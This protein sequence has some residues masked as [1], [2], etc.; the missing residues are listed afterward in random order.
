MQLY[1]P[2]Q[3]L[4]TLNHAEIGIHRHHD[5]LITCPSTTNFI[6][7]YGIIAIRA[8]NT[9]DTVNGL[10]VKD[11]PP[12]CPDC[13]SSY[14]NCDFAQRH[15]A[16]HQFNV[17]LLQ[18][19]HTNAFVDLVKGNYTSL[20]LLPSLISELT[21]EEKKKI[22]FCAF[23]DLWRCMWI[24]ICRKNAHHSP[25]YKRAY[26]IYRRNA[27]SILQHIDQSSHHNVFTEFGFP[28]G[29]RNRNESGL[30][31][32]IREFV[33]ESGYSS[34]DLEI[35]DANFNIKEEFVGSDNKYYRHVYYLARVSSQR[36]P[37]FD[38]YDISQG[39]E[40]RNLGWFSY[41][42]A[43]IMFRNYDITKVFALEEARNKLLAVG[44]DLMKAI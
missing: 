19:K 34:R 10:V 4:P 37:H 3:T 11:S 38:P 30:Q 12:K 24:Y 17:L 39:G 41:E 40:I 1:N 15:K 14:L 28:K 18:R 35:I 43:S 6:T 16:T 26:Q 31:C 21:C 32:A 9:S 42:Q 36:D 7:S 22:K 20:M 13:F 44:V 27:Q 33:E 25:E 5:T 29:R 2:V 23:E 8:T